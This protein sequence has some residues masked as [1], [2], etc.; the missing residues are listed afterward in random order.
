MLRILKPNDTRLRGHCIPITLR[1]LRTKKIQNIIEEMLDLVYSE[2][3]KGEK[4]DRKKPMTVGL[5]ANQVGINKQISIVDLAIGRKSF[6]DIHILINPLIIWMSKS[7]LERSE[8]CVNIPKVWGFVK[9]SKR[10]KVQALDRSGNK[11]VIDASGWPAILLQH[12]IGHLNGELF[13]DELSNPSQ[14]HLIEKGE[15]RKYKRAKKSW[16]KHIDVS[17][18]VRK[19][20]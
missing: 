15:Y 19:S 14:A 8:S 20:V 11:H 17:H 12:E 6:N 3:N 10:V 18:F 9:R 4:R 2:S 13:I 1:E 16:D 5:S 7:V